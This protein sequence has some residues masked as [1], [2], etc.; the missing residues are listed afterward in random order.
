MRWW[1]A[2]AFAL[3]AAVTAIAVSEVFTTR[4][5]AAFRDRAKDL[6]I[7]NSI[8]AADEVA[9]AL[10]RRELTKAVEE[11]ANRRRL[12]LFVFG[13]EGQLLTPPRSRGVRLEAIDLE[14]AL[15][16]ATLG[17]RYVS[18][19][20]GGKAT[21]VALPLPEDPFSVVTYSSRPEL[22]AQLGIVRDKIVEAALLAVVVGA[23]AGLLVAT[24]IA[25]RLR[26]I[27]AAAAAIE[28]GSFETALEP[29][30]GDEVG[31][32]ATSIDRMRLRL[33]ESFVKLESDRDRLR[34]LFERLHD[35][36]VMLDRRLQVEFANGAAREILGA[37]SL[38]EG[39]PLPDPWPQPS[40]RRLAARLFRPGSTT[41]QELV[42]LDRDRT[43]SVVGI[44]AGLDAE[45]AVLVLTDVSERERRERAERE[46]V[47]NA[48][49]E[50]R[51]PL[52]TITG[53][54]DVLQAGAKF[55]PEE[56]DRFLDHIQRESARLARLT[57]ALLVLA[58]AQTKEEMPL[59]APVELL[60]LLEAVAADLKAPEPV[61][62][63]VRCP[64]GLAVLGEPD[65]V[66]QALVNLAAN[67][68]NN[69]PSGSIELS[70]RPS[71]ASEV[72]IEVSDTGL[73]IPSELQ[74]RIFDRF[75]RGN[76]RNAK[77]FGLGLA[78]VHQAVEA[79]G[80]RVAVESGAGAGTT[81]R[82]TLPLAR[83]GT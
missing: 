75:F 1:L 80:G 66:E 30:F 45:T 28:A 65:L 22:V 24:L 79:L 55:K 46:F 58:R 47:T 49:H 67:A 82:V 44:P 81:V 21:L 32:L 13:L 59:L 29:R 39:D 56:R 42:S 68:A 69:T 6:A 26:R 9:E 23:L 15:E 41:V 19:V 4:S 7:G 60:P 77:G 17:K 34:R 38:A 54:V 40:L 16:A 50:L 27:A 78:I 71:G 33:R 5:E 10:E 64:P 12:A 31:Q 73:G 25:A 51:T 2:L 20:E 43:Y 70:A 8:G 48:A 61:R 83:N 3:I 11:I 37:E 72:T 62:V 74:D 53:A 57:R 52:S 14:P 36:V 76:G 35:G 18:A 63:E